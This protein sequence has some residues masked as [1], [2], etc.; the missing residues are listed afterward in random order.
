V[1]P[2][3]PSMILEPEMDAAP[4]LDAALRFCSLR[5]GRTEKEI[6]EDLRREEREAHSSLRYAMAKGL[7]EYLARLG[8]SIQG[9]Y[10]Y[11]ST[12]NGDARAG[13][14]IDLI[15]VVGRKLDQAQALL[16]RLD[17]ALLTAYRELLGS[18]VGPRSILDVHLVDADEEVERQGYGAV[19][20]STETSP[21]CLWRDTPRVS[22]APLAGS[23][24]AFRL[25]ARG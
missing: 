12:M 7:S 5:L 1:G 8:R 22:G 21:V 16:R 23:P 17:L 24:R 13:S 4:L 10:L 25:S 15:V 6:L 20:H 14:D 18:E 9:V 19:V 11:G 3:L 2:H